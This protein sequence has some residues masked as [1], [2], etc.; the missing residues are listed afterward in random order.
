MNTLINVKDKKSILLREN[1]KN[2]FKDQFKGEVL[3][4]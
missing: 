2:Q 3:S 4:I 1:I